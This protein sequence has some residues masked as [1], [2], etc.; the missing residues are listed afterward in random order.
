M[1]NCL[2]IAAAAAAVF[3]APALVLLAAPPPAAGEAALVIAPPWGA[4]AAA[5]AAAAGL[6]EVTPETAP[7]GTLVLLETPRDVRRLKTRGAWFVINGKKVL[8]LCA[9]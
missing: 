6:R 9:I 4:G 3:C 5:I 1:S 7:F 2:V 8:E